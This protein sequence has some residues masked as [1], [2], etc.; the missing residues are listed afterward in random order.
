[1]IAD[2]TAQTTQD[3]K[4]PEKATVSFV[5]ENAVGRYVNNLIFK[6]ED[7]SEPIHDPGHKGTH[8]LKGVCKGRADSFKDIRCC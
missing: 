3:G 7:A 2:V 6:V 5:F 1:M 4:C 8:I